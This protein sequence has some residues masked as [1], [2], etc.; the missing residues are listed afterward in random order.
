VAVDGRAQ[1]V[2]VQELL[3][4][5]SPFNSSARTTVSQN[6]LQQAVRG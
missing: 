5:I 3:H 2:V 4:A 1:L 6:V